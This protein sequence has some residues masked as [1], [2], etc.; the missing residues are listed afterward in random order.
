ML[1]G[2]LIENKTTFCLCLC[3]KSKILLTCISDIKNECGSTADIN[4]NCL[5]VCF[6][7]VCVFD[8][9]CLFLL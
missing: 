8:F 6:L 4:M 2:L 3:Q 5:S 7:F 9:A 1:D